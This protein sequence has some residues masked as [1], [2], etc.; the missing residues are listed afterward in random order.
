MFHPQHIKYILF[1]CLLA[2]VLDTGN[3]D[4]ETNSTMVLV[5]YLIVYSQRILPDFHPTSFTTTCCD[6]RCKPRCFEPYAGFLRMLGQVITALN[7]THQE[8]FFNRFRM[9]VSGYQR[10]NMNVSRYQRRRTVMS[11]IFHLKKMQK[12]NNR[13]TVLPSPTYKIGYLLSSSLWMILG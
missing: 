2:S 8:S 9:N 5:L 4:L 3:Q 7:L 6:L 10:L 1:F 11:I 13:K 12:I